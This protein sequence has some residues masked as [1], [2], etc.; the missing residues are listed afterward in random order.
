M[1]HSILSLFLFA[2]S[3]CATKSNYDAYL[4]GFKGKQIAEVNKEFGKPK[5]VSS[6]DGVST[7]Q[8]EKKSVRLIL[9]GANT[10]L[11]TPYNCSTEFVATS[12]GTIVDTKSNGDACRK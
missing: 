2:L 12:D 7:Y 1:K 10:Y 11:S 3:S 5:N 9:A 8:Y 4:D 6:K